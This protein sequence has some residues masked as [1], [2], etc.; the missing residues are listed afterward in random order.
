MRLVKA[1]RAAAFAALVLATPGWAQTPPAPVADAPA[2]HARTLTRFRNATEVQL[3]DVAAFVRVIPENRTDV[4]I[5]WVNA[6]AT[7]A[8]S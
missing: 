2:A 8:A 3:R 7:P 4:A 1:C 5:G 6:G